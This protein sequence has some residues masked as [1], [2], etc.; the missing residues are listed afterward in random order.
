MI[1]M[2][3]LP[4]IKKGD[5]I[6]IFAY[7]CIKDVQKPTTVIVCEERNQVATGQGSKEEVY[8]LIHLDFF[9][10]YVHILPTQTV[11]IKPKS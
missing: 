9:F 5:Q 4:S 1:Y 3:W 6:L 2:L 11:K 7:E 8:S 10:N